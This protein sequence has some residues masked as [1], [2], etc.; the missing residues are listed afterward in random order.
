MT[1]SD[2]KYFSFQTSLSLLLEICFVGKCSIVNARHIFGGFFFL[3]QYLKLQRAVALFFNFFP[4]SFISFSF[5]SVVLKISVISVAYV[6][7]AVPVAY[8][9]YVVSVVYRKFLKTK[10][11]LKE[12]IKSRYFYHIM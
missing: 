9:D 4:N 12:G 1:N 2:R 10:I 11:M 3:V 8:V 5:I 6:D 7:Y